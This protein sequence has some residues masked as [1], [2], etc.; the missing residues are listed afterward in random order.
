MPMHAAQVQQLHDVAGLQL[1]RQVA[2]IAEQRLAMPERA[3]D[4]V[5]FFTSAM[6]P[7]VSSI[8]L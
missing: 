4:D 5:A 8:V 7:L 1:G 2:R 6:R 3:D